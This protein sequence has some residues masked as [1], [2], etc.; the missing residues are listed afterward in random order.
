MRWQSTANPSSTAAPVARMRCYDGSR[1][2]PWLCLR[3][4]EPLLQLLLLLAGCGAAG[5]S[6]GGEVGRHGLCRRGSTLS[7]KPFQLP[8]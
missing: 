6:G 8:T 7:S 1:M 5:R 2:L 4:V 3:L